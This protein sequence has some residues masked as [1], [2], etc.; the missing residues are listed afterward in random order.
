VRLLESG[1]TSAWVINAAP[2]AAAT[3]AGDIV[4]VGTLCRRSGM[5]RIELVDCGRASGN[6]PRLELAIGEPPCWMAVGRAP[7]ICGADHPIFLPLA[8]ELFHV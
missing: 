8:R 5:R 4:L 1:I 2:L 7:D 6:H 3:A